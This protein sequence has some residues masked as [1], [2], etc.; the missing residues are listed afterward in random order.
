M[1]ANFLFYT[2]Q[3]ISFTNTS[4]L[5]FSQRWLA[6]LLL[7]S[8]FSYSSTLKT[9][10]VLSSESS[11]GFHQSTQTHNPEHGDETSDLL[12]VGEYHNNLNDYHCSMELILHCGKLMKSS[13]A[14]SS[15]NWLLTAD[16]ST[17]IFVTIRYDDGPWNVGNFQPTDTT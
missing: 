14:V 5:S 4:Y 17:T 7:H 10:A 12:C 15:V 16:V 3:N 11:V 6:S 9:E 13:W 1:R 2:P 8:C